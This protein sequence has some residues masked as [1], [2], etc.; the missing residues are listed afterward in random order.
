MLTEADSRIII[1]R[2][3][4]EVDWDIEDK[5]QIVTNPH[6]PSAYESR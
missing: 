2:K 6:E 1:D 3:L 5:T 4:R